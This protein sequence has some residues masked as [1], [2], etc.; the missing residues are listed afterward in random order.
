MFYLFL[1]Q[2]RKLR[3]RQAK[4]LG[5]HRRSER[6]S[7]EIKISNDVSVG[8]SS[9]YRTTPSKVNVSL[10]W[11]WLRTPWLDSESTTGKWNWIQ[12]DNMR[13]NKAT[14]RNLE[15]SIFSFV[16]IL[17]NELRKAFNLSKPDSLLLEGKWEV[18]Q[19]WELSNK[20]VP[21]IKQCEFPFPGTKLARCKSSK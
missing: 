21:K 12:R 3:F 16:T 13:W 7:S 9:I 1:S 4:S 17:L 10:E 15:I 5:Y 2:I 11:L 6:L 8:V 19:P 14:A 20:Y 18:E